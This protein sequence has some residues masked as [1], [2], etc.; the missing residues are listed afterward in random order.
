MGSSYVAATSPQ[1]HVCA[2][3]DGCVVPQ[4]S[5]RPVAH[6]VLFTD[7]S[8]VQNNVTLQDVHYF[9]L[10]PKGRRPFFGPFLDIG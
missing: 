9:I 6:R 4:T 7:S 5:L 10:T 3:E 1:A 8:V 2:T